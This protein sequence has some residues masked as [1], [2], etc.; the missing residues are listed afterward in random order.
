M[1]GRKS[2]VILFAVILFALF[3][4]GLLAINNRPEQYRFET[5]IGGG[6][7]IETS[8]QATSEKRAMV[9]RLLQE[10]VAVSAIYLE[11]IYNEGDSEQARKLVDSNSNAFINAISD[12]SVN[13]SGERLG[14]I[15][16]K[17][18]DLYI[19]YVSALKENNSQEGLAIRNELLTLSEEFGTVAESTL[20]NISSDSVEQAM[21]EHS[22]LTLSLIE[23]IDTG[24]ESRIIEQA[25][26]TA[27][28][29]SRLAETLTP[30]FY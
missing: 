8:E 20:P 14:E 18:I 7:P 2:G 10:H 15:W 25:A 1:R 4:F 17:Q 26:R 12:M 16:S 5:G 6:P 3:S 9:H 22:M 13:G 29:V 30:T 27:V 24:E 19:Q 28:Q 11:N 23:V 21:E